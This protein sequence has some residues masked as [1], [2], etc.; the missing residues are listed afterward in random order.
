MTLLGKILVFVTVGLSFLML[1]WAIALYTNRIDWTASQAKEGKPAGALLAKQD[2]VKAAWNV[3]AGAAEP[4]WREARN[5][6]NG[7]D[8]RPRRDGLLA[9]EQRRLNDRPWYEA[10][11]KAL[12]LGPDGNKEAAVRA[13]KSKDGQ[14]IPDAKNVNRPEMEPAL[15]RKAK[16]ED[17]DERLVCNQYYLDKLAEV[18]QLIEAEQV[19]YQKLVKEDTDL[20]EKVIGAKGLRQRIVD[21]QVKNARVD[22][23]LKDLAGRRTNSLVDTEL[24]LARRRQLEQ[25]IEELKKARTAT[26][27]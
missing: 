6:N 22:E 8:G 4:R 3:L 10:E 2:R 23:E 16:P 19:R 15:R 18:T 9:W 1:G 26:Q 14:P 17:P 24:L 11:L 25:R 5:G 21:E 27:D 20:T 12:R 13:V 7:N